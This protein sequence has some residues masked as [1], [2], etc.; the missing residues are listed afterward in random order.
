MKKKILRI[1][2][3][4]MANFSSG[5]GYLAIGWFYELA[6]VI[7]V[8]IAMLLGAAL[9]FRKKGEGIVNKKKMQKQMLRAYLPIAAVLSLGGMIYC[10]LMIYADNVLPYIP[11]TILAG[12]TPFAGAL[13][14]VYLPT[15]EKG[16]AQKHSEPICDI[17]VVT[18][19]SAESGRMNALTEA[20][21]DW[22]KTSKYV[23]R[24]VLWFL[25][26][27][28]VFAAITAAAIYFSEW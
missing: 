27:E 13:L 28:I 26:L 22:L 12:L 19:Q 3:Y 24:S 4:N 23:R 5:S 8:Y 6:A 15:R 9:P 14:A 7:P 16:K 25:G 20:D 17:P 18:D 11:A 21:G 2:P 1:R 10:G